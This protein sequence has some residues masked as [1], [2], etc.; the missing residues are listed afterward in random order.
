MRKIGHIDKF[1]DAKIFSDYLYAQ[2]IDNEVEGDDA[3]GAD[4]WV[5]DEDMLEKSAVDL[6]AF[7][8]DPADTKY[9]AAGKKAGD[10][11][12]KEKLDNK[13]FQKKV[14]GRD[15][16]M[17]ASIFSVAPV[18][19]CLIAISV[20][21]TLLGGLG[22]GSNLTQWLSITSYKVV[23]EM[24]QWSSSL[25]E[26]QQ[27]QVWRLVTPIFIHA[28]FGESFGI[29]HLL[30]NMMWLKDLGK[31]LENAQSGRAML[32]KVLVLAVLSNLGQYLM[33]FDPFFV[34]GPSFGGMSGVVFGLLGYCWMRGKHDLTSG[35]YVPSQTAKFMIVWFFLCL[36]GII[37]GVANGAHAVG[38]VVGVVWG[39]LSAMR[40]NQ[41]AK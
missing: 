7:L 27:G 41:G 33:F 19:F 36:F 10:L 13:K 12:H 37:P 17:H 8:L 4:V 5:H 39:Y 34:G 20:V 24:L 2:G 30:F 31:M 16:I 38:L 11:R 32:W 1:S 9:Q 35:L 22:S 21:V 18:T 25:P 6:D 23:G 28:S 3:E 40:V 14:H 29:L 26:I 15:S